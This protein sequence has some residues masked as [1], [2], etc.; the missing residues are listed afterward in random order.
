MNG[1]NL[2]KLHYQDLKRRSSPSLGRGMSYESFISTAIHNGGRA[3]PKG[4]TSQVLTS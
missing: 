1:Q 3:T 4:S 2:G